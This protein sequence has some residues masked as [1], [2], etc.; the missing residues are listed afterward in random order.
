MF[1]YNFIRII[2]G[3]QPKVYACAKLLFMSKPGFSELVDYQEF[4]QQI[5]F[6]KRA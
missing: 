4:S 3:F 5:L 1:L 2:H 6:Q